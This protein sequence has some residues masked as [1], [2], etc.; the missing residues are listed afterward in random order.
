MMDD[1]EFKFRL[2]SVDETS[3]YTGPPAGVEKIYGI[4]LV[5][6]GERT[7]MCSLTPSS[8]A[9]PIKKVSAPTLEEGEPLDEVEEFLS[10]AS[11]QEESG[12]YFGYIDF[13]TTTLPHSEAFVI[14]VEREVPEQPDSYERAMEQAWEEAIEYAHA[15]PPY[16][17]PA[18]C[19]RKESTSRFKVRFELEVGAPTAFEAAGRAFD[20][21]KQAAALT[22]D[23][24]SV[25]PDLAARDKITVINKENHNA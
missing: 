25:S 12:T 19:R 16:F 5:R 24:E 9:V 13:E 2:V 18:V 3:Y 21:V 10:E 6:E 7:H 11:A 4:Y 22:F 14:E 8:Y 23:V 17:D 1:H 20:Y 15:N